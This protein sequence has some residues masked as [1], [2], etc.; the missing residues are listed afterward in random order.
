MNCKPGDL[1]IVT[2]SMCAAD[3]SMLGKI[4]QVHRA[5]VLKGVWVWKL[6]KRITGPYGFPCIMAR[7]DCLT[8][9][10]PG[11]T[12]DIEESHKEAESI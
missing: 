1:A 6:K 9:I 5:S 8:A 7:D 2:G 3:Q 11:D 12:A 4:V 10:R